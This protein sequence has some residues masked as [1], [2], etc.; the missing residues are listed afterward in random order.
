[1]KKLPIIFALVLAGCS[2]PKP[3]KMSPC[4]CRMVVNGCGIQWKAEVYA[5][6]TRDEDYDAWGRYMGTIDVPRECR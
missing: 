1:M 2:K 5:D 4:Q 3:N 6:G